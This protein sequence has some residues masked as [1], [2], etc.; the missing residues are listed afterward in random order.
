[1]GD[2]SRAGELNATASIRL[3][4]KKKFVGERLMAGD[5]M[6]PMANILMPVGDRNVYSIMVGFAARLQADSMV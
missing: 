3:N 6:L 1:M 4:A 2:R 5:Q